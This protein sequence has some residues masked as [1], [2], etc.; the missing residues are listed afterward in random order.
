MNRYLSFFLL[1][2]SSLLGEIQEDGEALRILKLL[3][4]LVTPLA[5]EPGLPSHFVA[6]S[7]SGEPDLYDWVYWGPKEV[8]LAFFEDPNSLNQP[9][10][11]VQLSANVAQTGPNSFTDEEKDRKLLKEYGATNFSE[12]RFKWGDYPVR[13]IAV[14]LDSAR[15]YSAWIGLNAPEGWALF[16]HLLY[17]AMLNPDKKAKPT[18]EELTLWN[19]FLKNT[20]PLSDYL[21]FKAY[22]Q[23]I[24]VGATTFTFDESKLL[25][26]AERRLADK[27][28]QVV[29]IP[30]DEGVQFQFQDMCEGLMGAKWHYGEPLVKVRGTVMTNSDKSHSVINTVISV[31]VKDVP[32]FSMTREELEGQ[33]AVIIS[34]N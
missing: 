4:G 21:K 28:L 15:R 12:K 24:Q 9:I 19:N 16:A 8:L 30:L 22:G 5:V 32:A 7:Q 3:P 33:N 13:E 25:V 10:I 2:F 6:L 11:R 27:K 23:D 18:K 26:V 1:G 31:L 17:P 34:S 14:D 29:A 20:K